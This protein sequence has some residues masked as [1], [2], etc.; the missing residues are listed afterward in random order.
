M[1][2]VQSSATKMCVEYGI[3]HLRDRGYLCRFSAGLVVGFR[4]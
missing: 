1:F 3:Q 4:F 2:I